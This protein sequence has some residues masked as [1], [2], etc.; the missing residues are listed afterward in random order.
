MKVQRPDAPRQIEADLALLYQAARIA[1]D[2]VSAL[3][4]IDARELVDEFGRSIRQ[5][6]DYRHEARNAQTFHR[7]FSGT[8]TSAC[9]TC[10]GATRASA[11][12]RSS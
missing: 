5:E 2:R 1:K 3:D 11:C 8:R 9:R 6:L 10:T 4:F 7:N 12:S